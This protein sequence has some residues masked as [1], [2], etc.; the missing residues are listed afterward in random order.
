MLKRAKEKAN[1]VLT[2]Q[3]AE[4]GLDK[5]GAKEAKSAADDYAER[6]RKDRVKKGKEEDIKAVDW[7]TVKFVDRYGEEHYVSAAMAEEMQNKEEEEML[8]MELDG[9][10]PAPK[11]PRLFKDP[12]FN[13]VQ[14]RINWAV[15][16][17]FGTPDSI[18]KWILQRMLHVCVCVCVCAR[19]RCCFT[20][21]LFRVFFYKNTSNVIVWFL[22]FLFS[23]PFN[24]FLTLFSIRYATMEKDCSTF[25]SW[26]CVEY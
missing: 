8:D 10:L 25:R 3:R 7:D 4:F 13:A 20:C 1:K 24:S 15:P 11:L 26:G 17:D 18:G 22:L 21:S 19:A 14:V 12:D 6:R 2:Q 9:K 23:I 5:D 16:A